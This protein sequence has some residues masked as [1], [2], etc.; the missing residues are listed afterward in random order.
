MSVNQAPPL[1]AGQFRMLVI[2]MRKR[3]ATLPTATGRFVMVRDLAMF[4]V[5]FHTMN[6]GFDLSVAGAAQVLQMSG[7]EGLIFNLLFGKPLRESSQAVV[8][9][10]TTDCREVC[11]VAA[12]VECQQAAASM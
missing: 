5:A 7:G 6:R 3:M 11:D 9:R 10:R 1:V 12:M 8:V 4:W 2:D